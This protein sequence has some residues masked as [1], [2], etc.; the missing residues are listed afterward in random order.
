[1]PKISPAPGHGA[2]AIT[3]VP[4]IRPRT[5]RVIWATVRGAVGLAL[6]LAALA[7]GA[8]WLLLTQIVPKID[9][10]REPMAQQATA[11]LGVPVKIGQVQGRAVGWVPEL[12]LLDV[13]LLDAGGRVA[14]KLPQVTMRVSAASL[15][16]ISLWRREL[17]MES[18]TLVRPQLVVRRDTQGKLHV[19]GLEIDPNKT[20]GDASPA[21]DWLLDQA[22]IRIDQGS[23]T[24][25][26]EWRKAPALQLTGVDLALKNSTGLAKRV[27]EWRL[28][29]TPPAAFGKR[30]T[31]QANLSQA[32]WQRGTHGQSADGEPLDWRTR[33]LGQMTRAS[34][35]HS[36]SGT[37]N[38]DLP[39]VDVQSLKHHAS[40]PF[41]VQGGNGRIA[42]TLT[43]KNGQPEHLALD[44]DVKDVGMRLASQLAPLAFKSV[45][46]HIEAQHEPTRTTL[47]WQGLRFETDDG[48]RW[49][50]SQARL[51][52]EHAPAK[53]PAPGEV[54]VLLP[55]LH[56]EA[57][58]QTLGG[59]IEVDRLDLALLA[60]LADRVP[61]GQGLREQLGKL[62]PSGIATGIKLAWQ[63][64]ASA[65][66]TYQASGQLKGMS[67][68]A[69]SEH[70][71][72]SGAELD[73]KAH[74][75]GGEASAT[76]SQGWLEFPGVFDEPRI[77]VGQLKAKLQWQLTPQA[78]GLPHIGLDIKEARFA[79]E[80]VEGT[81]NAR[82]QT[83]PGQGVGQGA[84]YP[85][86]L[87][88]Q[89][90]L[91]KGKGERVWRYLP[92]TML[93]DA[94]HY[95]RD[96][97][98]SGHTTN[99]S[100]EVD[101]DLWDFPF[102]EDV[103]G[104]FRVKVP[105]ED[106][107]LDYVPF[108]KPAPAGAPPTPYWPPF[109]Q[110]S[111]LLIFEGQR[112]R[113][114]DASTVIGGVGTGKYR[115]SKVSA[116]IDDLGN[117]HPV[118]KAQGQGQGPLDDLLRYVGISPIDTWT[119]RVLSEAQGKGDA[120][121]NL[122][123]EVPL[124][125]VVKSKVK[126]QVSIS[127]KDTASLKLGPQVPLMTQVRGAI[128]FT[129]DT[130][131]VQA[132]TKVWGQ[133]FKI[134]GE[135][136]AQGVPRFAASG[137]VSG[138]ALRSAVDWPAMVQLGQYVSGQTPVVVTVALNRNKASSGPPGTVSGTAQKATSNARP[139]LQINSTLQGLALRLPAPLNKPADEAWPL[140]LTH[141]GEGA[142][143]RFDRLM[144]ELGGPAQILADYKRDVSG[145]Q[146]KVRQGVISIVQGTGG[147]APLSTLDKVTGRMM[148]PQLDVDAWQQVM[149]TLKAAPVATGIGS[150]QAT[151]AQATG[152]HSANNS[153]GLDGYL[154]DTFSLKA[155]TL[156][157]RQRSFK[158]VNVTLSR[159]T[160][161]AWHAVIDAPLMA[162][163]V[164]IKPEG[165]A[166]KVVARL[167]RLSVPA[168]EAEAL[169]D[170][171][172]Q[173]MLTPEPANV[174]ALDIVIDQF[175]WRGIPLGKLEVEA[176][177]RLVAAP[178][179]TPLTEWRLSKFKLSSADAQLQAQGNW[180]ALGAQAAAAAP[181]RKG[182]KLRHRAAFK[183]ALDLQNTGTMLSRLGLPQT[184]KGGK[185][186]VSGQVSWMGSPLEPDA[187][188]L[189]GDVKVALEEGQFL[190]ADPGIAKLLGV[191]SLQSL[192][193]RLSLDFRDVFQQGFAFDRVDGDV[194]INQGL[195]ETRNLRMR[196]V[197]AVVLMEG[198]ADL[199][200]ETQNLRVFVVPEIN[201]GTAS[202]AY[203][204]INPAIGLGTFIAQVL[205]RK[206]VVEA[207]T[208]EFTIKGSWADPQVEQVKKTSVPA[209][210][211]EPPTAAAS[212]PST[213]APAASGSK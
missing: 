28:A 151:S 207:S 31:A 77:P 141:R 182:Q 171:A 91:L 63:G 191:L 35:W 7:A 103:G 205:L 56:G 58:T 211:G 75:R 61:L 155:G 138:E 94:R 22:L 178:G 4:A 126:G 25:V 60:R 179:N 133:D 33:W 180:A 87:K 198:Q 164:D 152:T 12:T 145:A 170:Q 124:N 157:W 193:R 119:D 149:D 125:E 59:Q 53:P 1:M 105:L 9:H 189:S 181:T 41:D 130:L 84:R 43:V 113:I 110:M 11:A 18:L 146:P 102:K 187:A 17:H 73:F 80:D 143:T 29:A 42:L 188:S 165:D 186:K 27:H 71:G 148:V 201:A 37:A 114:E 154:P 2:P 118:L 26:D 49:P 79:N 97:V 117:G 62:A 5:G 99:A 64:P 44:A 93:V 78:Q 195:A 147:T 101:G 46:A 131:K 72:A 135:R 208:R 86:Q 192:P 212:A 210:E 82:W 204:A 108:V 15:W 139:E 173:Q 203:A 36:W 120:T 140:K 142:D 14:L 166:N 16:P 19:A 23:I 169:E 112:M 70:P 104:K 115:L 127:E 107:T 194:K 158:D 90:M 66:K 199:A 54:P 160:A 68:A 8:W 202:L 153:D 161:Q 137:M 209:M 162:G 123:M 134:N 129:Q 76:L 122:S 83:G 206:T 136:D 132:L 96:A 21:L 45:A 51:S 196:G 81:L 144:L 13:Q 40:L 69:T 183:F 177:N 98:R 185:G 156:S 57:W 55:E 109:S 88:M 48:L 163:V 100:F 67:W 174:P 197:Q 92:S 89:G 34:N 150:T 50:S 65:P 121:L 95:V 213:T 38:I 52:W 200:Q 10:W 176:N 47:Q 74:E 20:K 172:A 3:D 106:V 30:F 175:D 32:R 39:W 168:A 159:P 128:Q 6:A 190:K 24:W 85:G 116:V 184:L 111:G 167:S